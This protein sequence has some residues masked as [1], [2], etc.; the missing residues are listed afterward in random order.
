MT[1]EQAH[2]CKGHLCKVRWRANDG[3]EEHGCPYHEQVNN[4]A[5]YR[6]NCCA[7]CE[8]NCRDDV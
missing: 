8:Q 2:K 1:D 4:N 6:C 7:A 5:S 3:R